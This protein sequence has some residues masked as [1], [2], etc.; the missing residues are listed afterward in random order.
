[1]WALST[2]LPYTYYIETVC[3]SY[4]SPISMGA[5]RGGWGRRRGG[6]RRY[7]LGELGVRKGEYGGGGALGTVNKGRATA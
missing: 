7:D 2:L 4:P 1:M 6:G 5:E 3:L